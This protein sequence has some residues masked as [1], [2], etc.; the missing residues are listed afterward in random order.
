MNVALIILLIAILVITA[1]L[2]YFLGFASQKVI[3]LNES[4]STI[5]N[6]DISNPKST[7]FTY[8]VWIYINNWSN[9]EKV[10]VQASSMSDSTT[11]NNMKIYLD[12]TT[13]SLSVAITTTASN[14]P[15]NTITVTNNFPIQRWVLVMVSVEGSIVDCYLD[16]KLVKSKQLDALPKV[17]NSYDIK[18]GRFD[19]YI[20][21]FYR[22]PKASDPQTA[23]NTYMGGNGLGTKI[24][25]DIGFDFTLTKDKKPIAHYQ[26]Q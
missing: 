1:Y 26:Y 17:D 9:K 10:I 12:N 3:D 4:S 7:S 24:G 16:G 19:A 20:T 13:P 6:K 21:K 14:N 25:P 11:T 2:I 23:W 8:S 15:D 5:A 18:F 22:I